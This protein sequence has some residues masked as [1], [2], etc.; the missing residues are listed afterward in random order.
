MI[1]HSLPNLFFICFCLIFFH[2]HYDVWCMAIIKVILLPSA[3]FILVDLACIDRSPA[4]KQCLKEP[5]GQPW[6]F[7][8][9]YCVNIFKCV[10]YPYSKYVNA[11]TINVQSVHWFAVA[12]KR[13]KTKKRL[14]SATEF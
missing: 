1:H 8:P 12:R 7:E 9:L 5:S 4:S 2:I 11:V 13:T 10:K 14:A 3:G 6:Y